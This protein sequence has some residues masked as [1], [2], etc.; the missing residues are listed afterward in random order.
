MSDQSAEQERVHAIP[1]PLAN[2][3]QLRNLLDYLNE[4]GD[5]HR[6]V[7]MD[8]RGQP[9]L[10]AL[11]GCY[12]D[13]EVVIYGDPWDPEVDYGVGRRCDECNGSNF[14]GMDSLRFPVTVLIKPEV[15]NRPGE[16]E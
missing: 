1:L 2:A 12:A 6:A 16:R 5:D 8:S 11:S 10:I 15:A 13:T 4:S 9:F 7:G 3:D 14:H